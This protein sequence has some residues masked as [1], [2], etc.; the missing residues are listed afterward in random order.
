MPAKIEVL[1]RKFI[2]GN[3][4]QNEY[5]ELMDF[6]QS[7]QHEELVRSMLQ[8]VYETGGVA[9]V[10]ALPAR[11]WI[12]RGAAAA[13]VLAAVLSGI[14]LF[15][16]TGK[17]VTGAGHTAMKAATRKAEQK[18]MLL[19]DST[20]VWV[21]AASTL[22][23]PEKF[24]RKV[25]EV[26]LKGEAY[27][28]V[29]NADRVPFIVHTGDI[30]T[31]VLGTSFNVKAYPGQPDVIVAVKRGK[32]QVVKKEEV[33]AT[34]QMGQR[35]Q[36]VVDESKPVPAVVKTMK[37]E[38]V[39]VWTTGKLV[40]DALPLPLILEDIERTYNVSIRLENKVLEKEQVYTSFARSLGPKGALENICFL[41]D[42]KLT[43]KDGVYVIE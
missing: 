43:L 22:E 13:A 9:P 1:F 34:L 25:R 38:E 20:E 16:N 15:N 6:L 2:A 8:Q 7:N 40:Y 12:W 17:S 32:V 24:D 27:F 18:Y 23:F 33:V 19:P 36:V 26:Y 37:E 28:D 42:A 41:L 10:K 39:A 35:A 4:S 14:W 31:R 21:N 30:S 29:K 11:V 5:E 3:C